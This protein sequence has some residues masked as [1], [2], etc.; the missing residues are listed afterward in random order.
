[1]QRRSDAQVG[2]LRSAKAIELYRA[3]LKVEDVEVVQV[4]A[5]RV[6]GV[7]A[8]VRAETQSAVSNFDVFD[9]DE[10]ASEI[11]RSERRQKRLIGDLD[12][13]VKALLRVKGA[14][15]RDA[16]G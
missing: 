15:H 11:A 14:V 3:D 6:V 4:D 12:V 9:V 1:M 7:Y 2:E 8:V 16:V 5:A 13:R 10:V